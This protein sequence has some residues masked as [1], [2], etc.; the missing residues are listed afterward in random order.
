MLIEQV[1]EFQLRGSRSL[2]RRRTCTPKTGYFYYKTKIYKENLQVDYYLLLKNCRRQCI[3]LY[4][5]WAKSLT[6]FNPK[7]HDFKRVLDLN[8]K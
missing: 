6:N 7:M 5:N 2:G 8:Y 3:L 1:F 4:P